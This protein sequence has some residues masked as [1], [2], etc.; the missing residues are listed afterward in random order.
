MTKIKKTMQSS[1]NNYFKLHSEDQIYPSPSYYI[2]HMFL[3]FTGP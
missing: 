1:L 3:C 2:E